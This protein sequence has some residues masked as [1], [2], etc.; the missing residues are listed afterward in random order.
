MSV[1][2]GFAFIIIALFIRH[3]VLQTGLVQGAAPEIDAMK[4]NVERREQLK[5]TTEGNIVDRFDEYITVGENAGEAAKIVFPESYSYIIG[6]NSRMYGLSGLRQT[7]GYYLFDV[8]DENKKGCTVSLTVDNELQ[9]LAY[10]IL[11][12]REMKGSITVLDNKTGEILGLA[13]RREIDFDIREEALEKNW[14][15]YNSYEG[16]FLQ[17]GVKEA[18]APGSTFKIITSAAAFIKEKDD[19]IFQDTGS[20]V[21]EGG[22]E[23][24]NAGRAAYG[25]VDL[26][27][28]F[29]SSVNTYFASLACNEIGGK[30]LK[31]TSSAFMFNE[32]IELDFTTLSPRFSLG[33]YS[34]NTIAQTAFGQGLTQISPLYL[35]MVVQSIANEGE[36]LKPY[37]I[38]NASLYEGKKV[39]YAGKTQKLAN[40]LTPETAEKVKNLMISAGE[41]YGISEDGRVVGAKT[42]TAEIP[43]GLYHLYFAAFTEDYTI[44]IS[45]NDAQS[46]D[47][48][49]SLVELIKPILNYLY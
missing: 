24:H 19:Y 42:G 5:I 41:E 48:S 40:P 7:M 16:F 44:V 2:G 18:E 25:E 14:E 23:I 1:L 13:S 11:R 45:R 9:S 30:T 20:F 4:M 35:A 15:K 26:E 8:T 32:D 34:Q 46:Y 12:D 10:S 33:D 27:K 43:G 29:V 36:M 47:T 3:L 49:G 39:V 38:K 6:Y 22:A 37:L 31:E 21:P 28:A 17:L